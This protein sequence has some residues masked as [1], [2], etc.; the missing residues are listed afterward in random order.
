MC[1][2]VQKEKD[3]MRFGV[4][5]LGMWDLLPGDS[6]NYTCIVSNQHGSI[7]WTYTLIVIRESLLVLLFLVP[8]RTSCPTSTI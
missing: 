1:V 8:T 2:G 5:K 7:N 6:G 3:R 4:W